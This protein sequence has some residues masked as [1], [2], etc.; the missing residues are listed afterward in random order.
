MQEMKL[1]ELI[2]Q[3]LDSL[4]K[5]NYSPR[6]IENY[7]KRFAKLKSLSKELNLQHPCAQLFS[8]Y[9]EAAINSKTGEVGIIKQCEYIRCINVLS[10]LEK[11]GTINTSRKSGHAASDFVYLPVFIQ[12]L[13]NFIST[14]KENRLS[15]NTIYSY[16]RIVSYF[17]IYCEEKGYRNLSDIKPGD[18]TVFIMHLYDR[19]Y[20]KPTT[21][22]SALSGFRRFLSM[23]DNTK[24]FIAELPSHLPHE[25]KIIEI[26]S[27]S[28]RNS[29]DKTLSQ[30]VLS[31]RDTAICM[32]LMET[33]LRGVDVCNLKLSD[34]D[35]NKDVIYIMQEKTGHPLII[36]L[37]NSYGNVLADY[38]LHERPQSDS[39]FVFLRSLAP[40]DKLEGEG[41]S[42]RRILQ[43]MESHASARKEG[44]ISGSRMTRHN[45]ASTMLRAG[46]PMSEISAVLGHRDPNVVSVYLSTDDKTLAGCTLPLPAVGKRGR[47]S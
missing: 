5:L 6:T 9:L 24:C 13:E 25:R 18:I 45:A 12:L 20:F 16:K 27:Q 29:I 36:P 43:E 35:W 23:D 32:M 28:E 11:S 39:R 31:K 3:A 37:R 19:G 30:G 42:V 22:T 34:I 44:R 10:S 15:V 4:T 8:A 33:G 2:N 14:L 17:F 7:Q 1:E 41:S 40:F 47:L 38:I 21:I 26:Y 46:V